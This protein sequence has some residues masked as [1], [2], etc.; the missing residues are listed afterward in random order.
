VTSPVPLLASLARECVA[1]ALG[2]AMIVMFGCGSAT[3]MSAFADSGGSLFGISFAFGTV[4]YV[5]VEALGD[6]SGAH[7]N[8]AV[9]LML[10]LVAGLEWYKLPSYAAAQVAGAFAGGGILYGLTPDDANG[11]SHYR[12]GISQ[13]DQ[14][15]S[16][17]AFG[18]ELLGTLCITLTVLLIAVRPQT[19]KVH[20]GFPIGLAVCFAIIVTGPFTGGGINPARAI[21]AV[22]YQDHFWSSKAGDNFWVYVVGPF[23]ASLVA[24]ALGWLMYGDKSG[25]KLPACLTASR[26]SR[27]TTSRSYRSR[28]RGSV[29]ARLRGSLSGP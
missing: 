19:H 9:T 8:P 17:Q 28:L 16:A 20:P 12:S 3:S 1:E 14:L 26:P 29:A 22:C 2:T 27:M 21:G 10:Y 4:V 11:D 13:P 25:M 7:M 15:T 18:W 23:A 5:M 6:V 24:P